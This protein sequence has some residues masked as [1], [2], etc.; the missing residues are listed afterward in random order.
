[1]SLP[2]LLNKKSMCRWFETPCSC[3]I[4][5]MIQC[6]YN[7]LFWQDGKVSGIGLTHCDLV[8]PYD[9]RQLSQHWFSIIARKAP[10]HSL[11]Q[12]WVFINEISVKY[13]HLFPR[14]SIWKC[15]LQNIGHFVLPH[16]VNT[17]RTYKHGRHFAD[18]NCK[19][20]LSSK[21]FEFRLKSYWNMFARVQLTK[22]HHCLGNG[23]P[24]NMRPVVTSTNAEPV[25]RHIFASPQCLFFATTWEYFLVWQAYRAS[26][27]TSGPC[28]IW[29]L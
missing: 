7:L 11:N 8:T 22:S 17:L 4:T 29:K 13:K 2:L 27:K 6:G 3:D 23:L 15:Q 14:E 10:N 1:M 12:C 26:G 21:M 16:I 19:C 20:V 24:R 28:Q 9:V 18:D 5:V 25:H